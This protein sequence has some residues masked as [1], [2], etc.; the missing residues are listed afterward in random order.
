VSKKPIKS[1]LKRIDAMR[2]EDIDYS[3]IPPL[4][5][6]F[7]EQAQVVVPPGKKQLTLRLDADVLAWL[8]SLGPKYQT[9]INAILRSYYE[10]HKDDP[11]QHP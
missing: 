8:K 5:D 6:K 4:D 1:D 10:A 9:R 7:F 2:D 3:D 11:P